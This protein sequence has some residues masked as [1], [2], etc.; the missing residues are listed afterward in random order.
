MNFAAESHVDN[1]LKDES[2][3]YK[4]NVEG[5]KN[6]LDTC[7]ECNVQKFVQISTDEV[8]G[9]RLNEE[10]FLEQDPMNP[11]NPYAKTK[12]LAEEIVKMYHANHKIQT[13]ITRGCNTLGP[14]QNREKLIPKVVHNAFNGMK[15]PVYGSGL[16]KREWIAV[17][18]HARA[19]LH[20]IQNGTF[21]EI[22]NIGSGIECTN[23]DLVNDILKLMDNSSLLIKHVEDRAKHDFQYGVNTEKLISTGWSLDQSF[24]QFLKTTVE[25]ELA[26]LKLSKEK[27]DVSVV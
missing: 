11:R 22:Y 13:L 2:L 19:I 3:F 8:Y 23:I 4:T 12:M 1:S 24:E 21:G 15:I 16:Q 7:I 17:T 14:W 9:Q 5:V 10:R 25:F 20:L 27:K 26:R 6:L 18:E